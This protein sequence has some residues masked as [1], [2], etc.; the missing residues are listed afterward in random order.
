MAPEHLAQA[1]P[2]LAWQECAGVRMQQ[3][4]G[5]ASYVPRKTLHHTQIACSLHGELEGGE[6]GRERVRE[7]EREGERERERERASERASE[8]S[9]PERGFGWEEE[10]CV[11]FLTNN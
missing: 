5:A 1:G 8:F 11:F 10:E 3:T 2:A 9:L 7:G 4:G 6:R